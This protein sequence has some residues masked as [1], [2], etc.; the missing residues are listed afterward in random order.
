MHLKVLEKQ[1]QTKSKISTKKEV[2][3]RAEINE[4]EAKKTTQ[5]I[6]GTKNWFFE[7][8]RIIGKPLAK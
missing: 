4:I 6:N 5:K 1:E 3:I 7:K 2:I 8:V